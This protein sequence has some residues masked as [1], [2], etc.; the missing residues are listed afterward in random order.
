M[1]RQAGALDSSK[2]SRQYLP[3]EELDRPPRE[4]SFKGVFIAVFKKA[5]DHCK[6]ITPQIISLLD[7]RDDLRRIF[8]LL[9]CIMII[10]LYFLVGIPFCILYCILMLCFVFAFDVPPFNFPALYRLEQQQRYLRALDR[11]CIL[12]LPLLLLFL[13]ECLVFLV[14]SALVAIVLFF[15]AIFLLGP[16]KALEYFP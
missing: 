16:L 15:R 4:P 6:E 13:L 7:V 1:G 11:S 3:P 14:C 8:L 10:S 2:C 9:P 12:S 5:W